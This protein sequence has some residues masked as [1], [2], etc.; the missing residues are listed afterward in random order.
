M[1]EYDDL[2]DAYS[3]R[4]DKLKHTDETETSAK[5]YSGSTV[6]SSYKKTETKQNTSS[7]KS[8]SSLTKKVKNIADGRE[9]KYYTKSASTPIETADKE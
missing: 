1:S 3:K 2:F 8:F 9:K 7:S 5:R 6:S 4:S